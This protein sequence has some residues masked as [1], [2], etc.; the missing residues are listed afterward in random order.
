[1]AFLVE[2]AQYL[3]ENIIHNKDLSQFP[4]KYQELIAEK[5]G[6]LSRRHVTNECT[7]DIGAKAVQ[8]LIEKA[9]IDP[10]S[11][12]AL[13]CA[14]SSPDRIQPATATRIQELC[15]LEKA[16]AFDINSVCSGGVYALKLAS[17]LINDGLQ[18][19]IVVAAEVY[20]KI[21]NPKDIS[22]FPY[23]GDGAGAALVSN[24][25]AYELADFILFSDGSGADVIKVAAGG[26]ML[27]A[28]KVEKEKDFYF[29]MLGAEVFK[30]ACSKGSEIIKDLI[31]RNSVKP[32]RI[33]THQANINIIKEIAKRTDIPYENFFINVQH[34][35]NTAGA[36]SLIALNECLEAKKS[37]E[38][39]FLAV[40]GGGLSWAGCYLK[41]N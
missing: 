14:T 40:F 22:T 31:S 12:D 5:A 37:E 26:T 27:P 41:K 28:K 4:E 21:L 30:F 38:N 18:N 34:Y 19:V 16:F 10:K 36:S 9:G 2:T 7:S 35:A 20:S 11:V 13:I 6:I 23:F 33:I 17:A 3:P 39:I 32:D 1:M 29:S 8:L 24:Q 25:G 15:G